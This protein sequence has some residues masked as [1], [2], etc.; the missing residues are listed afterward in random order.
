MNKIIIYLLFLLLASANVYAQGL[1]ENELSGNSVLIEAHNK[2]KEKGMLRMGG[3]ITDTI[4]LGTKGILDDFSKPGPYPDTS[5]WLTNYVFIN[6]EYGKAPP[7]LGVATF[8]GLNYDGYPYDFAATSGSTGKAD[9]LISKPIDL[10]YPA[11][12]S[13]YF[14]FFYQPQGIG[15]APEA[16]DSLVVLFRQPGATSSWNRVWAKKGTTLATNDSS[17]KTVMIPITNP[18]YLQ[19]GFQFCFVNYATRS[20]NVDHWNIDYVYLNRLRHKADSVFE[21]VAFVYDVTSMLNSYTEMPWKHFVASESRSQINTIV[22]NN[23]SVVKNVSFVHKVYDPSNTVIY[24]SLLS[25][26]N[27]DPFVSSGYYTYTAGSLPALPALTNYCDY[28]FESIIN[29]TPD[30]NRVN[31]TLRHVQRFRYHYAYDDGTAESAFGLSTL[32]AKLAE[33]FTTTTDDTL[34]YIDIYFNPMMLNASVYTFRLKLWADAGGYPGV[35][36]FSSDSTFS[37]A[38]NH[39]GHNAFVRY[40]VEP[41]IYLTATTFHIG[42]QQNTNQF[43][44][45]GVDKN[46]NTQSM[47]SYNVS[48]TWLHSPY[49]GSL[50][51]RPVFGSTA[52]LAVSDNDIQSAIQTIDPVIYPNPAN[53]KLFIATGK[54]ITDPITYSIYDLTGRIL[55]S[56]KT[57]PN[58]SIDITSF[59][60]GI[61]FIH[62]SAANKISAH[63]FVI[64][65]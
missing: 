22:R 19:K 61:Y 58:E 9:S 40:P 26:S 51:M 44:N 23:H 4:T 30:F 18:A 59:S 34:R 7:T 2:L 27:V 50:M 1:T 49:P 64:T 21:D 15:N 24:T 10:T 53:D 6:N 56:G 17:W 39:G 63:K 35:E 52:D 46:T 38:Y 14:S 28:T 62:L 11:S 45:I 42:L 31:D 48:G 25:A 54:Q 12:D 3:S 16:A 43:I 60:E 33:K 55:A 32:N 41:P 5:L 36:V 57:Y 29:S 65:K 47:I 8:D 37:P 20:G 13:L